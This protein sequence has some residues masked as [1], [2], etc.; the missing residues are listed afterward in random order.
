M[1]VVARLLSVTLGVLLV[2]PGC[3]AALGPGL[4]EPDVDLDA[5]LAE[6]PPADFVLTMMDVG[7]GLSVLLRGEDFSLLYDGGSNDD[8]ASG[9]DS[10]ALA[11]LRVLL[12][13][14]GGSAACEPGRGDLPELPLTHLVLSHPHRDHLSLLPDVLACYAV[15]TI[16]ESGT[17]SDTDAY[18]RFDA[19]ASAEANASRRIARTGEEIVLGRLARARILSAR[20]D[21]ADAN[22]ASIVLRV[23]LG[24]ASVLF[25]GD[26]E[27]GPRK[28]P[29]APVARGSVEANLLGSAREALDSDVLV[30]GHHGSMTSSRAALLDAVSPRV[31]LVSSG[32][33]P[34]GRTELP[35]AEVLAELERRGVATWQTK[36]D[37]EGCRRSPS[38]VGRDGDGAPGGCDAV[39]VR[40]RSDG[41]IEVTAGPTA[42]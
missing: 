34:Y 2:G 12:G 32:P 26:A 29:S 21:A 22:D 10:R 5:P 25:M 17:R 1:P 14:S 31:A 11:Y 30:V 4:G 7:T 37:D 24:R 13:R 27:G 6:G 41:R 39:T 15:G 18:A 3:S 19:A 35:D 33:F 9:P 40:L 28:P 23:E 38:K 42:D 16:W 8:R 20:A 36:V